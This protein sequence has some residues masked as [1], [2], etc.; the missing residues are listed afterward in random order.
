MTIASKGTD[1]D[2]QERLPDDAV[3]VIDSQVTESPMVNEPARKSTGNSNK[4][5]SRSKLHLH[6]L[7]QPKTP[8]AP[9]GMV[10]RSV[11]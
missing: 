4:P 11:E 5:I 9:I 6:F 1:G 8:L 2:W 3:S 7:L 10:H